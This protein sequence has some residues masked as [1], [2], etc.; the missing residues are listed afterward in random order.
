MGLRDLGPFFLRNG[1]FEFLRGR[2]VCLGYPT[3]GHAGAIAWTCLGTPTAGHGGV[4]LPLP[5]GAG[6]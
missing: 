1:A 5:R 3:A 6:G 4:D 2:H